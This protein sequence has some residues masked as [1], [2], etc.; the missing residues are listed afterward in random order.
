MRN[1]RIR[2]AVAAMTRTRPDT[3]PWSRLARLAA[4]V[5]RGL[6]AQPAPRRASH[7]ARP[8]RAT[9]TIQS[10]RFAGLILGTPHHL[11]ATQ[12]L[13]DDSTLS[14]TD[15]EQLEAWAIHHRW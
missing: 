8:P 1:P 2:A 3:S 13:A 15:R 12:I 7:L 6:A 5:R 14:S 11:Q 4:V 10:G 9:I